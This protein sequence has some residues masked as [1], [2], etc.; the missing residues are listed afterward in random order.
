MTSMVLYSAMLLRGLQG[1]R[2]GRDAQASAI[3]FDCFLL[4]SGYNSDKLRF[5][6]WCYEFAYTYPMHHMTQPPADQG[7]QRLST[8]G[9]RACFCAFP[10]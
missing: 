5:C 2:T 9:L 10:T 4:R 8:L 1:G 6:A 7:L 3:I